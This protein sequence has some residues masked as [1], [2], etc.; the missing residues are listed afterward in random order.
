MSPPNQ[1]NLKGTGTSR[2]N[3]SRENPCA[4][5]RAK[6]AAALLPK[7]DPSTY[8]ADCEQLMD[9]LVTNGDWLP[10]RG[11]REGVQVLMR[12]ADAAR[13]SPFARTTGTMARDFKMGKDLGELVQ[14]LAV[15]PREFVAAARYHE[16]VVFGE[17]VGYKQWWPGFVKNFEPIIHEVRKGHGVSR[18]TMGVMSMASA[19]SRKIQ[20]D[21]EQQKEA[22]REAQKNAAPWD[23][24][25]RYAEQFRA[26]RRNPYAS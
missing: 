7:F 21:T 18:R 20:D 24:A 17:G 15:T 22:M 6:S 23:V 16:V 13:K 9:A 8:R 5:A 4:L 10:V 26:N 11:V 1:A 25:Q 3:L 19:A 14:A 12:L 2:D